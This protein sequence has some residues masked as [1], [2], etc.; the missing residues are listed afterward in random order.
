MAWGKGEGRGSQVPVGPSQL[1][2]LCA[3]GP[4][5]VLLLHR[6]PGR[7]PPETVARHHR[8]HLP[9]RPDTCGSLTTVRLCSC[10]HVAQREG[11]DR[12]YA[13]PQGCMAHRLAQ[14]Q[15]QVIAA[16]LRLC[17]SWCHCGS[18]L[19]HLVVG[20]GGGDLVRQFARAPVLQPPSQHRPYSQ[21]LPTPFEDR[22]CVP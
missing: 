13:Q 12:P 21:E 10:G 20:L 2:P 1:G 22:L 11:N 18:S 4:P 16:L 7:G 6:A 5:A 17:L 9:P 14:A 19:G 8:H 3:R 15:V